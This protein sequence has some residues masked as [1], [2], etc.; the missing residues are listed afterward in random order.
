VIPQENMT[1]SLSKQIAEKYQIE[2]C[3]HMTHIQNLSSILETGELRSYNKMRGRTYLNLSNEDVQ[4][5]RA[6]TVIEATGR[7]LHEYVPFYLGF[8]TPMVAVNQK[9]N[10]DLLFLQFNLDILNL[11]GVVVSDGNARANATNFRAYVQLSDLDFLDIS[12]IRGI[13]Y[14]H[15]DELKRRKQ[16][17][18]LVPDS[19]SLSHLAY[20]KCYSEKAKTRI[21]E[22]WS[23]SDIKDPIIQINPGW[24]F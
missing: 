15:D 12:A 24:Y 19:L 5:G 8:K 11:G 9:H 10:E 3:Y 6:A 20:I 2:R 14:A 4:A 1:V 21:L 17:E 16:A 22:I 13:K 7:P 23:K 18:V